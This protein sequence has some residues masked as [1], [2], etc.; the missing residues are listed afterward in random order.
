M[1]L[2]AG[3]IAISRHLGPELTRVRGRV[4]CAAVDGRYGGVQLIHCFKQSFLDARRAYS[5]YGR[6]TMVQPSLR[7]IGTGGGVFGEVFSFL[8]GE[9]N[10]KTVGEIAL[11]RAGTFN[12][13]PFDVSRLLQI[14]QNEGNST[15]RII[16][17]PKRYLRENRFPTCVFL[18]QTA[19]FRCFCDTR[20]TMRAAEM[21][22]RFPPGACIFDHFFSSLQNFLV[23]DLEKREELRSKRKKRSTEF[24][25]RQSTRCGGADRHD[26]IRDAKISG[27]SGRGGVGL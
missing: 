17:T 7:V 27:V 23:Y 26:P 5:T 13:P 15:P 10:K 22:V 4:Y 25:T 3:V 16:A 19:A 9:S 14:A 2:L 21:R 1:A 11:E 20:D 6:H 12:P 18:L 24:V 8:Q